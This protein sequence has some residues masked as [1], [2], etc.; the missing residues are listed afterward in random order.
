MF[1]PNI[2]CRIIGNLLLLEAIAVSSCLGLS[3]YGGESIVMAYVWTL[4]ILLGAGLLLVFKGR[5]VEK[6]V[7]RKDSYIVVT[8][9]WLIF[10]AFAA[11]PFYFSGYLPSMTDAFFEAVSGFTTTGASVIDNLEAYPP[12][13]LFW[14]SL[15]QW[16]GGLGIV[17]FTV[18]VMPVFGKG[19]MP[20]LAAESVG[21]IRTKLHPQVAVTSRWILM[22]YFCLTIASV[23]ALELAGM[24]FF[25]AVCHSMAAVSTGGFSTKQA[26]IAAY[27]SPSIEYVIT[28]FMFLGGMNFSL[29]YMLFFKGRPKELFKD[30]EFRT[31]LKIIFVFTFILSVGLFVSTSMDVEEAFRNA[32]FQVV[33]ILTTTGFCTLD[34]MTWMPILWLM[35]S[36][37]M[38]FGACTGSTTGGI[39]CVRIRLLGRI[40]ANEFKKIMHPNL[41][42]PVK[43]GDK[44]IQDRVMTSIV[45]F[46]LIY[47]GTVA[48]GLTVNMAFGLDFIEAYGLSLTSVGNVGPGLG[49]YGPAHTM[50]SLPD[51]LKW[52]A[53]FQML[54][55]R[56]E[57]FA[58]FVLFTRTFWK[59]Q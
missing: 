10:P 44:V 14:R 22:V 29:L 30:G 15:T 27:Q 26:S 35:V 46:I 56:L 16:I 28:L 40:I 13:L 7:S 12:S 41:V 52:F 31:Y 43:L 53:S 36:F 45:A 11:L 24:G 17:F 4:L 6:G 32:I 19:N 34:Y 51:V 48:V 42:A 3:L 9:C 2:I 54:I 20:L 33:T 37:L 59:K 57:F 1:H 47:L 49:F 5:S 21:P 25:D 23:V 55:G 18:A 50:S 38:Y 39:K 8:L 58:M